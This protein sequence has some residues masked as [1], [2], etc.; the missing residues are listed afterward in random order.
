MLLAPD[1]KAS[2]LHTDM[3]RLDPGKEHQYRVLGAFPG[4]VASGF[5]KGNATSIKLI[6]RALL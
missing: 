3:T 5:P 2:V 1:G 4:K 6:S